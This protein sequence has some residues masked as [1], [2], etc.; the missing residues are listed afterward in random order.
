LLLQL[1]QLIAVDLRGGPPVAPNWWCVAIIMQQLECD[2]RHLMLSGHGTDEPA[3]DAKPLD[4][5]YQADGINSY[6]LS[7]QHVAC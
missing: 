3:F 5:Y 7:N 2:L 1:P 4:R 6:V